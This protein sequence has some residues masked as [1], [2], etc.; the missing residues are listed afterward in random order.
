[1]DPS[2]SLCF[3]SCL[4]RMSVVFIITDVF[5]ERRLLKPS[6]LLRASGVELEAEP[7]PAVRHL[8]SLQPQRRACGCSWL[9]LRV[10]VRSTSLFLGVRQRA[11]CAATVLWGRDQFALPAHFTGSSQNPHMPATLR[12]S[13]YALCCVYGTRPRYRSSGTNFPEV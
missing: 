3:S 13:T 11:V 7:T 12:T 9:M 10:S 1:M 5:R 6:F 2:T 4:Q 8:L